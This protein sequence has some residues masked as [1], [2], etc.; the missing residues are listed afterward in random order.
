MAEHLANTF[1]SNAT[2]LKGC[3]IK[4]DKSIHFVNIHLTFLADVMEM[5]GNFGKEHS[6]FNAGI[7]KHRIQRIFL[8]STKS[9][10]II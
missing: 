4:D 3:L 9:M 8:H 2:L 10:E 1:D 5:K 6:P 7:Q